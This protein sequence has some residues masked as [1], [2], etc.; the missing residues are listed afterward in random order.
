MTGVQTCALPIFTH[1][2]ALM[3]H[4][5]GKITVIHGGCHG[6]DTDFHNLAIK[7][8]VPN[9][10][11]RPGDSN[12][13]EQFACLKTP[14][15][16]K[17]ILMAIED[18]LLRDRRIVATCD[19]LIAAPKFSYCQSRGSGTWY[20]INCARETNRPLTVYG[21]AG[22]VLDLNNLISTN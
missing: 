20:T 17:I 4:Y 14:V 21:P 9:I 7:L 3:K 22:E 6:A 8:L 16:T 19:E 12:Q 18:Y 5:E 11:V 15:E 13:Y 10:I 2:K 1:L